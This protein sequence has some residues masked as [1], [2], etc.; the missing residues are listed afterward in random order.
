MRHDSSIALS[1]VTSTLK[2]RLS[3]KKTV[4]ILQ[5][6][7]ADARPSFVAFL[8]D[9]N[10]LRAFC[11]AT[12]LEDAGELTEQRLKTYMSKKHPSG[13]AVYLVALK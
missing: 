1:N 13:Y 9:Y 11:V 5:P 6:I 3:N 4:A 10:I 12:R 8:D 2:N 7:A